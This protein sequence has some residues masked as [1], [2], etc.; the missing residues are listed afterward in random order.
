MIVPNPVQQ[1]MELRII[2]KK[3]ERVEYLITNFLGQPVQKAWIWLIKG[4]NRIPIPV[5]QLAIGTYILNLPSVE[6]KIP[7]IKLR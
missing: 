3:N 4:F 7:F 1:D 6:R 2:S 5:S